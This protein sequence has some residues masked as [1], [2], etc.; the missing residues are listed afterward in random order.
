MFSSQVFAEGAITPEQ[1][2]SYVGQHKIVCGVVAQTVTKKGFT[3]VNFGGKYPKQIFHLYITNPKKY[4]N[5]NG[6][7]NKEVCAHGKIELY[8]NKP[9]ITDPDRLELKK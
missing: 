1:A 2:S 9:E 7:T 6:L 8:K 5:L 3:Y 4:N